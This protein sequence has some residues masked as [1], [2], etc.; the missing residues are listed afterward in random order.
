MDNRTYYY[1]RVSSKSQNLDRQLIQFQKIGANERE[2]I[3]D[4]ES[5]KDFNRTGYMA[6]KTTLLRKGDTL[7]V[8]SIDRL[9]RN[10]EEVK[11]ELQWM[12]DNQI[13]VKI[14][15]IPTTL[16]EY[17]IG[18]E[19]I[20]DLIN[21]ILIEVLST[22]AEQERT[23]IKQRQREG[24]EI[25]KKQGKY[26]GRVP[27]EI[28]EFEAYYKDY[29]TRKYN[30]RQLCEILKVSRPTL[31]KLIKREEAKRKDS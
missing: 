12:K 21:T 25:A 18:Q 14:L 30:K 9:G 15:D 7:V 13:R 29:L 3:T 17:P 19:W 23:T 10:K 5:G 31:D 8:T 22:M 6:L 1:A 2:I 16:T 28:P 20:L 24:I 27:I 11:N 26:K 4:K